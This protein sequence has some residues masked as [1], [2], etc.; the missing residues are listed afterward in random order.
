MVRNQLNT[1][2]TLLLLSSVADSAAEKEGS[3]VE[4]GI[5]RII[6]YKWLQYQ[7]CYDRW[8]YALR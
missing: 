6:F 7:I 8:L 3:R 2:R 1:L 4:R 5:T